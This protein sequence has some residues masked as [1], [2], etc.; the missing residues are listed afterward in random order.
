MDAS[1]HS[2]GGGGGGGGDNGM[3]EDNDAALGE[4]SGGEEMGLDD[5]MQQIELDQWPAY[6]GDGDACQDSPAT[7]SPTALSAPTAAAGGGGGGGSGGGGGGGGGGGAPFAGR[8]RRDSG[9]SCGGGS[10]ELRISGLD[11]GA[12]STVIP[13]ATQDK[14]IR[15]QAFTGAN[16]KQVTGRAAGA[17]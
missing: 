5:M 16:L 13:Q 2:G 14:R 7:V 12:A 1:V 11:G 15:T 6:E 10:D 4:H 9:D 8:F 3:D 17:R